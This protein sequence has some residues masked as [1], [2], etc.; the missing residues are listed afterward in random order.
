MSEMV[1]EH[2]SKRKA[3]RVLAVMSGKGGVGKTMITAL[4]A[5]G[6]RRRGLRVGVLDGN[7][8]CSG[9]SSLFGIQDE[10]PAYTLEGIEP[11]ATKDGIKVMAMNTSSETEGEP[12]V[13]RGPMVSS[14]FDQFYSDVEWGDLDFLLID[15]PPGMA[16]IAMSVLQTVALDGVILVSTPQEVVTAMVKK[17]LSMVRQMGVHVSG[18]VENMAYVIDASGEYSEPFGPAAG[19]QLAAFAGTPLLGQL[20]LDPQLA[21]LANAGRIE[22]HRSDVCEELVAALLRSF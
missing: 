20:P 22:T 18:V 2:G 14:A 9:V 15:L 8:T 6:L 19:Q 16:D 13:W 5:V 12:I 1:I 3:G 7:I 11:P 10:V 17:C 21:A 4:L